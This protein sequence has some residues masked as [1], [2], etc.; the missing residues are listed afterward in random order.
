[1]VDDILAHTVERR[2][3][4]HHARDLHL[5]GRVAGHG[6]EQHAAQGVAERVAIAALERLHRYPRVVRR[7][8]LDVDNTRLEKSGLRHVFGP[9][10][11]CGYFEYSSMTRCS[12]IVE[13]RSARAGIDLNV[14]LRAFESTSSHSGKPRDSAASAAALMRS[15]SFAFCATSM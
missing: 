3:L 1:D 8:V 12:L 5:G 7:E 6:G 14:P 13:D 2:V 11:C 9:G 10:G 4:V 15:C